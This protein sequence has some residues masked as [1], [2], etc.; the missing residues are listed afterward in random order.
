[1]AAA[2]F[3][4]VK[5]VVRDLEAAE[6]FYGTVFGLEVDHRHRSGDHEYA[7][8]ESILR[9]TGRENPVPLILA[10]YLQAP[11]PPGGSA[12]TGFVVADIEASAVALEKA[13]GTIEVAIHSPSSHPVK[14]LIGR[15]PD[16][17]MIEVIEI[18]AAGE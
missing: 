14:A 13:G 16:G 5:L 17:H 4:F 7:Q 6:R 10:Q 18:S 3:S 9:A 1:M 2:T 8:Q 15:D 12:W 11:I